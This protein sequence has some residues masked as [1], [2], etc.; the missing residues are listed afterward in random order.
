MLALATRVNLT[1]DEVEEHEDGCGNLK[2]LIELVISIERHQA[3]RTLSVV[4][5][6][7]CSLVLKGCEGEAGLADLL[8]CCNSLRGAG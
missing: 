1:H 8:R 3:L 7:C 2:L 4:L 5:A 6:C